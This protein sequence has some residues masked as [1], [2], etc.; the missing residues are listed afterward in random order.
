M[1]YIAGFDIIYACQDVDFDKRHQL[2]SIPARYGVKTAMKISTWLHVISFCCFVLIY[3]FFDM[4]Y[5]YLITVAL[6]GGLYILEHRLVNPDDLR[7][8]Q[9]AFFHVN[10]VI[11]V[12]LFVGI[13]ADE[14]IRRLS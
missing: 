13:L 3:F 5:V 9:V 1:T 6:I 11:S 14:I 10:S 8:I 2:F 12:V 7:H 4:Q